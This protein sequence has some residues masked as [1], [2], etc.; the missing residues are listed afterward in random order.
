MDKIYGVNFNDNGKVYYF[1]AN[2]NCP[3]NVTVI[4]ETEK[5]QQFGKV[6]SEVSDNNVVKKLGELKQIIR[7]ATKDDYEHHLQNL[8]DADKALKKCQELKDQLG[9]DMKV[10]SAS[11]TFDKNQLLFNFLAD[12]RVD[13]RELAR[14]LASIYRTRIELRQIG[15]RDKA[16]NISGIGIC[17]QKLC[18]SNFLNQLET[19]SINM[20]KN[21]NLALNPTKI[22]G[23][24]NRLL[25]CLSY[26]DEDYC[27]ARQGMPTVGSKVKT[28]K[29]MGEVI[30]VDILNRKYIA[31]VE[32]E[33]VEVELKDNESRSNK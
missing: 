6:V 27:N 5:G 20:A 13:F 22:N 12:D 29:G 15:P 32:N 23:V 30:N 28:P 1:K 2:D 8:K 16:K 26:E 4:V 9:L 19:V 31:L 24:C 14:K 18:C 10:I 21:Q 11:F 7:I 33:K 17:G 25:C 3:I